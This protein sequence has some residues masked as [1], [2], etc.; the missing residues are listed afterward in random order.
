VNLAILLSFGCHACGGGVPT[1]H[2]NPEPANRPPAILALTSGSELVDPSGSTFLTASAE[3]PDGDQLLYIW[4]VSGGAI[5]GSGSSVEWVLPSESDFYSVTLSVSDSKGGIDTTSMEVA[6]RG[7][8]LLVGS[9]QGLIAFDEEGNRSSPIPLH[10]YRAR[11]EVL[12]LRI[13]VGHLGIGLEEHDH[14]GRSLWKIPEPPEINRMIDFAVLP[15]ARFAILDNL[16][17]LIS[18]IDST[19]TVFHQLGWKEGSDDHLQNMHGEVVEERLIVSETGDRTILQLDLNTMELSIFREFSN[20]CSWL[21]DIVWAGG[22]FYLAAGYDVL[23]FTAGGPA[24]RVLSAFPDQ[25]VSGI[26]VVGK[27]LFC[28]INHAG[29][30]LRADLETGEVEVFAEGLDHPSDIEFYPVTLR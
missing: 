21:G 26:V 28:T 29:K 12:G 8:T 19:G 10:S 18:I 25:W 24:T 30:V 7:F 22:T 20:L 15:N 27:Y 23:T 16:A 2:G 13:F 3:D 6:V 14:S 4:E 17:D 11:I 1:D 5:L 9:D